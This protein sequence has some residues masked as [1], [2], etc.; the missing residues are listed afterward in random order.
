[1]SAQRRG[2]ST[3]DKHLI[4]SQMVNAENEGIQRRMKQWRTEQK[5]WR[6]DTN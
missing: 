6:S 5:Y 3:I 4:K 2:V 1:M